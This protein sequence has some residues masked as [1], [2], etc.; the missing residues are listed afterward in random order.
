MKMRHVSLFRLKPE[1]RA[2]ELVIAHGRSAARP[3]PQAA[4]HPGLRDRHQAA[5]RPDASPDGAVQF[6]DLIQIITFANEDDCA[7]YPASQAHADF[8]AFSQPYME[9]VDVIDY[10]VE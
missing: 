6:Y 1:Y 7:A 9:K 4:H 8:L 10:P 5:G 3:S 2:P